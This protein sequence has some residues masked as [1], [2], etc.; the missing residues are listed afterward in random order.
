MAADTVALRR[1]LR[2]PIQCI[3][4]DYWNGWLYTIRPPETAPAIIG[5]DCAPIYCLNELA[6]SRHEELRR[7]AWTP[8]KDAWAFGARIDGELVAVCWIQAR[9]T[10]RKRGGLLD[11]ADDEAELAQITTAPSFQGRGIASKLIRYAAWQMG[12]RG[13][14]K[15]YAKIW[16]G[17]DASMRAFQKAGWTIERRF[18]SLRLRGV[19]RWVTLSLPARPSPTRQF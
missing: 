12:I 4:R 11:L 9:E 1:A 8:E 3:A 6:A 14:R 18:F 16:R 2:A 19:G 5:L 17:N 10:H 13:F 7:Q 15:L